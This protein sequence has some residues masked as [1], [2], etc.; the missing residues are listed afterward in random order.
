MIQVKQVKNRLRAFRPPRPLFEQICRLADDL[1]PWEKSATVL[2]ITPCVVWL[3]N[4]FDTQTVRHSPPQKN[5]LNRPLLQR[6]RCAQLPER[7]HRLC[8]CVC[9][10][11][12]RRSRQSANLFWGFRTPFRRYVHIH[13]PPRHYRVRAMRHQLLRLRQVYISIYV[14]VCLGRAAACATRRPYSAWCTRAQL[15]SF[16]LSTTPRSAAA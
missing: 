3:K 7:R 6:R 13:L 9:G 8:V 11:P 12:A 10:A 16:F 2:L 5:A 1:S 14:C 4:L 15:L